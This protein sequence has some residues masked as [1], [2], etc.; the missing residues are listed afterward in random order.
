MKVT[1][2]FSIDETLTLQYHLPLELL[3][4]FKL[5]NCNILDI[6]VIAVFRRAR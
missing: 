6:N 1:E 3:N 5:M 4:S 2:V